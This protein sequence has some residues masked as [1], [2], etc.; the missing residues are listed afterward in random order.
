MV[1]FN[2]KLAIC[3]TCCGPTYRKTALHKLN[4]LHFDDPNLYYF[5]I[6][7]DKSY[8][9][10][11]NRKNLLVN[12]LRDFYTEYP[13]LEVYES[14]LESTDTN[15]YAKKFVALNY[16]FP[17]STNRLHFKQAE[18]FNICNVAMLATD[19]DIDLAAINPC[20]NEKNKL[21]NSVTMWPEEITQQ[22]MMAVVNILQNKYK[23]KVEDIVMVFDAAAKFFVFE[24][25]KKMQE[26]FNVWNDIMFT[27]YRSNEIVNF[28][29]GYARN[30]E[31]ILAPIYNALNIRKPDTYIRLF[32][33]QHNPSV[34]RFW[35]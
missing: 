18:L 12:E 26:F 9:K 32:T 16:K 33:P 1:N 6:T 19:T 27:L 28:A 2:E 31:Y 29:G 5:I 21:F 7:D 35:A 14:F 24:S 11:V 4:N 17:F 8:F 30:D 10:D 20:F 3:Y 15:D 34:E 13:E 25:V 22:N 23:L